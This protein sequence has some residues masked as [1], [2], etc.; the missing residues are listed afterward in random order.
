MEAHNCK[1]AGVHVPYGI[2]MRRCHKL[3]G[4]LFLLFRSVR[5]ANCFATVFAL[6]LT[7]YAYVCVGVACI[8]LF[9]R[10]CFSDEKSQQTEFTHAYCSTVASVE[11]LEDF[12]SFSKISRTVFFLLLLFIARWKKEK[13]DSS[14]SLFREIVKGQLLCV[15]SSIKLLSRL[16]VNRDWSILLSD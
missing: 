5:K 14:R 16:D 6:P 8:C 15:S 4:V 12:P 9:F 3:L 11:T 13:D 2:V 7:C 1:H 10:L